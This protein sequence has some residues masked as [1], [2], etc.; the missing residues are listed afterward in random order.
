MPEFDRKTPV[1]DPLTARLK[2]V[3]FTLSQELLQGESLAELFKSFD[4]VT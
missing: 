2:T 4:S 1:N 3:A